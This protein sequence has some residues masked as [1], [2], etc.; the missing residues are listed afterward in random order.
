MK[1]S[2]LFLFM[3]IIFLIPL[4]SAVA[5]D[6]TLITD[7][8]WNSILE[9]ELNSDPLREFIDE[10]RNSIAFLSSSKLRL[11]EGGVERVIVDIGPT[12]SIDAL[13]NAVPAGEGIIILSPLYAVYGCELASNNPESFFI[14]AGDN[15][16]SECSAANIA[17]F[18]FDY[19]DACR[20]AGVRAAGMN[21]VTAVMLYKGNEYYSARGESFIEGWVSIRNID[22]L[23]I[24]EFADIKDVESDMIDEFEDYTIKESGLAVV[25][26]GPHNG[27]VLDRF[28]G[29]EVKLAG[30]YLDSWTRTGYKTCMSVE[31]GPSLILGE[32]LKSIRADTYTVGGIIK[33]EL[34]FY[35]E[36]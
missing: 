23:F 17:F 3:L 13:E 12:M 25:F 31:L 27:T 5:A 35:D 36:Q 8:Y 20:E 11:P 18:R 10:I 21:V 1:F 24:T 16:S 34:F 30:E 28:D 32:I 22:E 29:S 26:A 7:Q 4:F 19:T 14:I 33:A 15:E 9:A 6:I 2:S